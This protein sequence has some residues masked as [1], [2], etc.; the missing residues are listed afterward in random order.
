M[1][2]KV[3]EMQ[4]QKRMQREQQKEMLKRAKQL[5]GEMINKSF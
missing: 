5:K 1:A 4:F 2:R 3:A